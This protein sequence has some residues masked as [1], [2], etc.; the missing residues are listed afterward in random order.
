MIR[1]PWQDI[2]R[3]R[4]KQGEQLAINERK[5]LQSVSEV[6]YKSLSPVRPVLDNEEKVY[7]VILRVQIAHL[8]FVWHTLLWHK[9]GFALFSILW[10]AET[11]I[12]TSHNMAVSQVSSF[13]R[14]DSCM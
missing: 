1:I 14:A 3:I 8:L 10:M 6:S 5:M 11:F 9:T 7:M 2:K 12:I 4:L 13:R